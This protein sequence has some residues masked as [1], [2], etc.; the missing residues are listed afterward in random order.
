MHE[1]VSHHLFR[2]IEKNNSSPYFLRIL[3][4]TILSIL[5]RLEAIISISTPD[6]AFYEQLGGCFKKS[7]GRLPYR[8]TWCMLPAFSE[9][10]VA[11]LLLLLC[12]NNFSYFMF[13]VVYVCFPC[14]VFVPGLHSFM[15][16]YKLLT[17]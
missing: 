15:W 11:H 6:L 7:G 14:L 17:Y 2:T 5:F 12:M 8:C 10:R 3:K 13:V 1:T 9:V 4:F 16:A